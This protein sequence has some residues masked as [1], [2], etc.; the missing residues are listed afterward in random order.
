MTN[1]KNAPR[2]MAV[3]IV[4]TLL[5]V[6]FAW[7]AGSNGVQL[8]GLS[9]FAIC[10]ALA[11]AINWIAFVPAAIAQTEKYYDLVGAATYISMLAAA[12]ALS[13][14][15]DMRAWVV[16]AMVA[17]WSLRLGTFLFNRIHGAGGVDQRFDKIKINPPRFLVA[18]TLQAVW[19]II[20]A[21][22]AIVVISAAQ[23]APLDVFFVVGCVVWLI[24]FA[25]EIIADRQKSAFRADPENAG[26]YID[27]GLW[28][29]SQHPNYFGE[30]TLWVGIVIIAFPLL[31][32]WAFLV[33]A[34]P[35]F[36]T[37]LLTKISGINMLDAAA[38]KRWGDDLDYQAYRERTSVLVPMPPRT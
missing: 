37:L 15:L 31:S 27:T 16:A 10:A 1:Y 17:I 18:W 33:F 35:I 29:W 5:G 21:S 23:R 38:A 28:S 32:G 13:A 12:C 34:S 7:G 36:I 2:S 20:T 6:G 11:F 4:A 19:T 9:V 25:I 24:G 3:V 8:G 14:P 30:I 26:Q 22:A